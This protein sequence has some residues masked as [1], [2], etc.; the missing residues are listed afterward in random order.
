[1]VSCCPMLLGETCFFLVADFDQAA[2]Q[3][4]AGAF[5]E[6]CRQ[7]NLPAALQRSR[8]GNDVHAGLRCYAPVP[9]EV[10]T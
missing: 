8:L 3:D 4:D 9:C 7:K 5:L 1:M 6:T 10:L 2:W